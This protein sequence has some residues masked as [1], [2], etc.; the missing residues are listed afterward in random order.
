M[1]SQADKHRINFCFN[2]GDLVL[3]KLQP[4]RQHSVHYRPSYKLSKRYYGPYPVIEKIGQV[5]YK[6]QL[7]NHS[8]IHPVFHISL[9]KKFHGNNSTPSASL[10]PPSYNN[11]P[12][13]QPLSI[14]ATRKKL[15][16]NHWE[17]QFLIHW[18]GLPLE[19]ATWT[20]ATQF[21][22]TYPNFHLEDKVSL[23]GVS[24]DTNNKAIPAEGFNQQQTQHSEEEIFIE[25]N[26]E[27]E[28]EE[29]TGI[30]ITG[31]ENEED[32]MS[33]QEEL[34]EKEIGKQMELEEAEWEDL[35]TLNRLRRSRRRAK[36][37]GKQQVLSH[38]RA[39]K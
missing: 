39:D 34:R 13:I 35:F 19:E 14:L 17:S 10:P 12:L 33:D 25:T 4:Y 30:E 23:E 22:T 27:L 18:E 5:A 16:N 2:I 7:P 8:K 1:K 36:E 29:P 24:I 6:L 20:S 15:I 21:K 38:P 11:Q 26:K 9:L 31:T 37:P 28:N 3:V 32:T